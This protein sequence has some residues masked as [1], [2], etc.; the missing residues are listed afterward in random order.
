MVVHFDS[1]HFII[2]QSTLL[3]ILLMAMSHAHKYVMCSLDYNQYS[4]LYS[5]TKDDK[6]LMPRQLS[7]TVWHACARVMIML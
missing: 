7:N 6:K 3:A 5:G 1:M 4:H 2:T